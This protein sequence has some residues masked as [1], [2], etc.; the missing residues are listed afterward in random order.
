MPRCRPRSQRKRAVSRIVPDPITRPGGRPDIRA[1]IWPM[2][3]TGFEAIS[4]TASGQTAMTSPTTARNT[5]AL[6]SSSAR[7]VSPGFCDTPQ[8][9]ITHARPGDFRIAAMAHHGGGREGHGV[10]D[11]LGLGPRARLVDIDKDKLL[12][13]PLQDQREARC[14]AHHSSPDDCYFHL[15]L[16]APPCQLE[17]SLAVFP[18]AQWPLVPR[19]RR[20]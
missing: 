16:H 13:D 14:R 9:R 5:S 1:V 19:H 4:R 20:A 18:R 10:G 11:I 8:A 15:R 3:S 7:R 12:R 6:R 17:H 2:M